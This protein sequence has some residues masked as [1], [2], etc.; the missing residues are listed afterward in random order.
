MQPALTP[1]ACRAA[2]A[3]LK[4]TTRDLARVSGVAF[5]TINK[6][7]RGM[8]VRE[9]TAR[10]LIDGFAASGVAVLVDRCSEGAALQS[11]P[12]PGIRRTA[13]AIAEAIARVARAARISDRAAQVGGMQLAVLASIRYNPGISLGALARLE[14][15]TH[16]TMSRMVSALAAAGLV[17]RKR[18]EDARFQRLNLTDAGAGMFEAAWER[19]IALASLIA[20]QLNPAT[21]ADLVRTLSPLA[22][23]LGMPAEKF[24][25]AAAAKSADIALDALR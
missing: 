15:V 24:R 20:E 4:W 2:R 12:F 7:E 14:G 1:A 9:A 3:L 17:S 19:R 5:T 22:D 10:K 13:E 23:R 16:P 6:L 11:A 21:A 25:G 18:A 8:P